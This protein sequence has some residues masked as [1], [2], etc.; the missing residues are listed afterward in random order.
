MRR[1]YPDDPSQHVSHETIYNAIY[2]YPRGELR[3]QLIVLL[4]QGKSTRRPR[5]FG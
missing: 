1:M 4:R 3:K 5:S 2:A